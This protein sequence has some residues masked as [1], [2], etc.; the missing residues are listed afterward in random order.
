MNIQLNIK[1]S[2]FNEAYLPYLNNTERFT[3]FYGGAGSG[4][5]VFAVQKLILKMLKYPKRTLLVIRKV[6]ASLRD[7]IYQEFITHLTKFGLI[8][9]CKVL[10]SSMTIILPNEAKIIFKGIDDPEKLKSI[11]GIDDIMIEEATE[12]TLDDFTQLN[13]RLRSKAENQQITLC[14][15]PVSKT[16]WCYKH[17]FEHGTPENTAI[18]HTTWLHNKFLPQSYID[19]L[20]QMRISNPTY[21]KIYA[22]GQFATLSKLVYEHWIVKD[23]DWKEIHREGRTR[24]L[25]GLDFGYINDPTA[26]I[27]TL[28]D[29]ERKRLYIFDEH[30]EKGL[31]NDEI[32]R[33]IQKKG[34]SKEIITA[35]SAEQKSI[36]EIRKAGIQRIRPARKGKDSVLNGIQYVNQYQIIVHPRCSNLKLELENYCWSKDKNTNEYTNKPVDEYNHLLDALRYALEELSR[37]WKVKSISRNMFGL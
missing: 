24:A 14:F 10:G 20:E 12:L 31:L 9:Y 3:V 29:E 13:L 32:A 2:Y 30:Y 11:S 4:K 19:S 18:V 6:S 15:N 16:N 22:E 25:F 26:F 35:D 1:K 8:D 17:W 33:V 7:S 23:F 28:V 27:C 34:Y 36:E 5:S 37:G 21:Y